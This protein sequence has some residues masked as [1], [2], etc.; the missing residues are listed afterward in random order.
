MDKQRYIFILYILAFGYLSNSVTSAVL[1][2]DVSF[3]LT[4][5]WGYVGWIKIK[6]NSHA[7][8]SIPGINTIMIVIAVCLVISPLVPYFYYNQSYLGTIISQRFNYAIFLL[9]VIARIRPTEEELFK[10]M[11]VCSYITIAF[12]VLSIFMPDF[13]IDQESVEKMMN[14]KEKRESTD[15]GTNV[16]GIPL[17]TFYFFYKLTI[18]FGKYTKKDVWECLALLSFFIAYQNRSTLIGLA[19]LLAYVFY[20]IIKAKKGKAAL[21]IFCALLIAGPVLLILWQSLAQETEEQIGNENYP[22]ILAIQY[23]VIE[24]KDSVI[25]IIFGNGVWTGNSLYTKLVESWPKNIFVSDIGL[26][27]TYFY[28]GI[29]PLIILYRYVFYTLFK[30]K[31]PVYLRYYSLWIMLV[32]TIHT[33]LIISVPSNLIFV[34]YFYLVLYYKNGFNRRLS[35]NYA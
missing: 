35:F 18:F 34:L 5:L 30:D 10:P 7:Q 17:A 12:F 25:K 6:C 11:R 14:A 20:R 2:L 19:P 22:R 15:I 1:N 21:L 27:G 29:L 3:V 9:P 8:P 4:M 32:P 31:M 23:Y 16:A 28:Y 33:F 26:L 13:F 24:A